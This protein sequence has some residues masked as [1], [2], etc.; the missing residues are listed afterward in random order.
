MRIQGVANLGGPIAATTDAGFGFTQDV[1]QFNDNS[2]YLLGD[3]SL[4]GGFD[5]QFVADTRRSAPAALYTFTNVAT[6]QAAVSGANPL[7][8]Q[9]FTQY[10]GLPNL[11]Y[12]SGQ[13]RLLRPG[14]LAPL[15]V[16]QGALR[17]TLRLFSPPDAD[18][19]APV[20]ASRAYPTD[21]NNFAPRLG[22]VWSLGGDQRSVIRAN[23]GIMYDQTIN[24]IYEQAL[25]NDGTNARASATFQPTQVGAPGFPTSSAPAPAR[26]RTPCRPSIPASGWRAPGR[27]TSSSSTP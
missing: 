14:R 25:Q 16:L 1:M 8:Y 5:L 7:G 15:A 13:V 22:A 3:H 17:R 6:Y 20:E 27:T 9:S 26:S 24:A 12:N 4:K 11:K 10:F 23:T 19:N 18:P 21:K 2:T